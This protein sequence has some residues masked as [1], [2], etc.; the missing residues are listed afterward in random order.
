MT[1][2]MLQSATMIVAATLAPSTHAGILTVGAGTGCAFSD[3]Q[4]ALDAAA[5]WPGHDEIRIADDQAYTGVALDKR[6]PDAVSVRGGFRSCDAPFPEGRSVLDGAGTS[7]SVI[8]V[9]AGEIGLENLELR[10]GDARST[11]VPMGGGLLVRGDVGRVVLRNLVVRG[12]QAQSGGGIAVVGDKWHEI[13]FDAY[14]VHVEGNHAA[15]SGGGLHVEYSGGI[16]GDF[17]A[18]ANVADVS[19][20]GVTAGEH[21][22]LRFVQDE[23]PALIEGNAAGKRGGGMS[24][25]RGAQVVFEPAR[26]A[27]GTPAGA[28]RIRANRA[29]DGGGLHVHSADWAR[30]TYVLARALDVDSNLASTRG[31]A[32]SVS[33]ADEGGDPTWVIV[34]THWSETLDGSGCSNPLACDRWSGNSVVDGRSGRRGPGAVVALASTGLGSAIV[35]L[36]GTTVERNLGSNLFDLAQ[37]HVPDPRSSAKQLLVENSLVVGNEATDVLVEARGPTTVS[38]RQS[39]FSAN[40]APNAW[41]RV[42]AQ[43]SLG[44]SVFDDDGAPWESAP[45]DLWVSPILVSRASVPPELASAIIDAPKFVDEAAWDFRLAKTSPAR[46]RAVPAPADWRDR[47]GRAR[48][49]DLSHNGTPRDLGC[50]EAQ[51]GGP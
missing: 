47:L 5:A 13:A 41:F 32:L 17:V 30:P 15:S 7:E 31:G 42:A 12:N 19:G 37:D 51:P 50:F 45:P 4:A 8:N 18:T 49:V 38:V 24:V 34:S 6:D 3:I 44:E 11:A 39:T 43:L 23:R 48:T 16:L 46:D 10:G 28:A 29:P 33:V 35:Q 2:R 20:G 9:R 25:E 21:A 40:R 1:P 14:S 22:R 36:H 27:D 26:G